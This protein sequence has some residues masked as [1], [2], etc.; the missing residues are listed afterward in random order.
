MFSILDNS[1]T[2]PKNCC[3]TQPKFQLNKNKHIIHS[4]PIPIPISTHIN[5]AFNKNYINTILIPQ[6]T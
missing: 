4:T 3:P 2:N 5:T 6:Y 1:S